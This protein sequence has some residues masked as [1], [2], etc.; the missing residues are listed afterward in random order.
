MIL[1][2]ELSPEEA[3]RLDATSRFHGSDPATY[4]KKL[5]TEHSLGVMEVA[6][7]IFKRIFDGRQTDKIQERIS[8]DLGQDS[9]KDYWL[10]VV[11]IAA[12]LHDVGHLPFPHADK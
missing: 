6:T 8:Q 12:L 10:S 1:A 5:V 11:R 7:K 4:A 3:A 9:Q 2:L